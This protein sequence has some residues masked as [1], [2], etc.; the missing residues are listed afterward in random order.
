MSVEG[1]LNIKKA[2]AN[3]SS[4]GVRE[5]SERPLHVALYAANVERY[6][7]IENFLLHGLSDARRGES[8]QALARGPLPAHA[9]QYDLAIYDESVI[10]P[11]RALIF[12]ER[13]PDRFVRQV[14]DHRLDLGVALARDFS[15]FRKPFIER[16]ISK[17]SRDNTL[18]SLATALPDI[19]PSLIELPWSLAEF[20]SDSAFL[21]MNQIHMAFLIAGASDRPVGYAYQKSEIGAVI[22]GAFGWRAIARELIGKIPFGGGLIPKAAIAY[23]GTK[24]VGLSLDRF[25]GI[26]YHFTRQERE[27]IYADALRQGKKVAGHILKYVRP[28]L[29]QRLGG[30]TVKRVPAGYDS[31]SGPIIDTQAE[32]AR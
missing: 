20:A 5:Q 1:L 29:A 13:R 12:E 17:T 14:L 22:A 16:V 10:A 26:G 3:L 23:A 6:A 28:D 2:I 25:Y 7:R 15:A 24:L 9:L 19:V 30:G 32:Q 31:S 11:A 21:T 4:Q 8:L 27:A 18:F